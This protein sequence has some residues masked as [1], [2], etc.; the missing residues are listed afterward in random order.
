MRRVRATS[1]A[2]R[3]GTWKAL[4]SVRARPTR[5]I[6]R[7]APASTAAG[8]STS[9]SDLGSNAGIYKLESRISN[10]QSEIFQILDSRFEILDSSGPFLR[11]C[12]LRHSLQPAHRLHP[13]AFLRPV[14]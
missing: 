12:R 10:L 11:T 8:C 6:R 14:F 2:C 13:P 3:L 7:R 5:T 9:R 4:D 1:S